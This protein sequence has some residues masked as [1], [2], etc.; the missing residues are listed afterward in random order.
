MKFQ[1]STDRAVFPHTK[2]ALQIIVQD[3]MLRDDNNI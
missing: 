3:I 1:L 2:Y